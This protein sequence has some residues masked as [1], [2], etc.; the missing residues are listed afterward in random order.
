MAVS[1]VSTSSIAQGFP[2]SRSLLAGN[3]WS[4]MWL[5]QRQPLA[6]TSTSTVTFSNIPQGYKHL[7]IRAFAKNTKTSITSDM[8][9]EMQFNGDTGANYFWHQL[10]GNGTSAGASATTSTTW[11]SGGTAINTSSSQASMFAGSII[12]ILDY[13]STNKA[14][15]T[16]TLAGWDSN[17]AG[18]VFLYS[19]AWKPTVQ[20]AI[21][22]ITLN[23][24]GFNISQYSTFALY[25]VL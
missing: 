21:T 20:A 17:G 16:R 22:S 1:R 8:N 12:D 18:T 7:Q 25:G 10:Y 4:A 9:L 3:D 23:V 5:I 13:T 11:I 15:T 14:K 2:K 6:T 19:G 24:T